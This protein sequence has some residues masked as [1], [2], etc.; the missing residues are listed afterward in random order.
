MGATGQGYGLAERWQ[1]DA[2]ADLRVADGL[3]LLPPDY[4]V[5]GTTLLGPPFRIYTESAAVRR[6]NI[7][8]TFIYGTI[9]RPSY[10]PAGGTSVTF[11]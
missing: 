1:R 2:A 7:V 10:T 9:S 6:A 11:D 3:Q 8:N 5:P 4:Q